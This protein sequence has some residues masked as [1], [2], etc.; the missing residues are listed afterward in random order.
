MPKK[1]EVGKL[2]VD[3]HVDAPAPHD[4]LKPKKL[5]KRSCLSG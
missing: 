1:I 3:K 4:Y 2:L 5:K